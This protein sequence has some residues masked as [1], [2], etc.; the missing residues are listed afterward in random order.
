MAMTLN[1]TL[2]SVRSSYLNRRRA[3]RTLKFIGLVLLF[4]FGFWTLEVLRIP[5]SRVLEMFGRL[6]NMI[7]TRL[8]RPRDRREQESHSDH[9]QSG[10]R[11]GIAIECG[12]IVD[13][14]Q[15]MLKSRAEVLGE[16]RL[17]KRTQQLRALLDNCPISTAR[18]A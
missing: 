15:S 4:T 2:L 6:G 10:G 17:R 16:L 13:V 8:L 18:R 11:R 7:A 14:V 12:L 5:I 9:G 1:Q 3:E